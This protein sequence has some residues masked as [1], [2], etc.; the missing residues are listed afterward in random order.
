MYL[1]PDQQGSS[2]ASATSRAPTRSRTIDL[3]GPTHY[4]DYGGEGPPMLLVH[5]LGGSQLNWAAV[6]PLLARQHRVVALDLAG[7]GH[8]PLGKRRATLEANA[9]LIARFIERVFGEPVTLVGNSMGGLLG[10]M[11]AAEYPHTVRALVLVDASQAL[12]RGAALDRQVLLAFLALMLPGA[13]AALRARDI[14]LSS[15]TLVRMAMRLCCVNPAALDQAVF[16][17]HVAYM[18]EQRAMPWRHVAFLTA[19]RSTVRAVL[20]P[21]RIRRIAERV[22]APTLV[23]HGDGDRLIPLAAAKVAAHRRGWTLEVFEGIGHV[24][25]LECPERFVA[26]VHAWLQGVYGAAPLRAA[27]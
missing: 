17:A 21:G 15:K 19:A 14:F 22:A 1:N 2:G 10:K 20:T 26:T 13:S 12:T 5:G 9:N 24:P 3:D 25:Q 23:I 7:F 27:G 6:A 4:V 18:E 16:D 11:V 8:T